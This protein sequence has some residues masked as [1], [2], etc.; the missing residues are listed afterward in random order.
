MEVILFDEFI[1]IHTKQLKREQQVLPEDGV[2][3]NPDN[4]VLVIFVLDL[5]IPQ[6]V[7]LDT[8]LVLKALFIAD[9]FN[10]D[11]SLQLVI[12]A[13]QG[14]T[15]A[16]GAQFVENFKS[17]SQMVLHDHLVVA[18]L[19]VKTEV[20]AQKARGFD[21]GGFKSEE[22]HFL[23]ILNFNL[24]I[25]CHARVLEE[26]EGLAAG[27]REGNFIGTYG[28]GWLLWVGIVNHT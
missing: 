9:D 19:V 15:K 28:R 20:V 6:Q 17:V 4:I 10:G 1:K 25:I 3:V 5:Q 14:L 2:V 12:I 8:C 18:S 27:H 21:L 16:T 7:Q 24:F 11:Y 23:V 22:V 26:L 13:L